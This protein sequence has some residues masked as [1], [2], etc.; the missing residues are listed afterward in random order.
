MTTSDSSEYDSLKCN[1]SECPLCGKANK[2]Q[3]ANDGDAKSCWCLTA[4]IPQTLLQDIPAEKINK[5]CV[6][7]QCVAA[8]NKLAYEG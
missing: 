6:C 8:A 7:A 2:C 5:S 3:M 4:D 1:S